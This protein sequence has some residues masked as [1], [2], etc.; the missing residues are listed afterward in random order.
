LN[1]YIGQLLGS[2][3]VTETLRRDV[4][5][6][7]NC[8]A[9]VLIAGEAGVGKATVAQFIHQRSR[10]RDAPFIT[11]NCAGMPETLQQS[12]CFGPSDDEP[13]RDVPLLLQAD[14]GTVLFD[15]IGHAPPR[16]QTMLMRFLETG[17]VGGHNGGVVDVR[18]IAATRADLARQVEAGEF[19]VD[20]FYRLNVLRV[21]LLPLR[22]R[23]ED[24][25]GLATYLLDVCAR[26]RGRVAPPLSAD[27]VAALTAYDWPGN[28][29]QLRTVM[30]SLVN[31][32]DSVSIRPHDLVLDAARVASEVHPAER[33]G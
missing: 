23:R 8:D 27:S 2:R 22:E 7:V 11:I 16:A 29:R 13:T 10:R 32:A 12:L 18:V 1:G 6:A 19:Y 28:V 17:A 15:D 24:I 14:R 31:R 25:P 21:D 3:R 4:E 30:D 33:L 9:R 5:L 26:A 20:L